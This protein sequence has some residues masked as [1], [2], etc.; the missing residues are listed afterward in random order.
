MRL[1]VVIL[2]GLATAAAT[3]V[4]AIPAKSASS[5]GAEEPAL[6]STPGAPAPA[7]D[8]AVGAALAARAMEEPDLAGRV[9]G[10][11]AALAELPRPT[12]FRALVQAY[13]G[14]ALALSDRLPEARA[15]LEEAHRLL[16]DHAEVS[17]ALG[18][19]LIAQQE[20]VQG[21]RLLLSGIEARPDVM[22]D[23]DPEGLG[24]LFRR[25]AY[26]REFELRDRL[27]LALVRS[28]YVARYPTQ[29]SYFVR[30]AIV[31]RLEAGDI[32]GATALL[33][34]VTEPD[35]AI[36]MIVARQYEKLWP[37]IDRWA[38]GTLREQRLNK[39]RAADAAYEAEPSPSLDATLV[40]ATALYNIGNVAGASELLAKALAEPTKWDAD[41]TDATAIAGRLSFWQ[42][43]TGQTEVSV[44]TGARY[45]AVTPPQR[46]PIVHNLM[47]NQAMRLALLGRNAEALALLD[48]IE[49]SAA[50]DPNFE[51]A[52]AQLWFDAIRACAA[53]GGARDSEA[54]A[55]LGR[56]RRGEAINPDA[57]REALKC[58]GDMEALADVLAAKLGTSDAAR[59]A[60]R[61]RKF[62]VAPSLP[63]GDRIEAEAARNPKVA[64]LLDAASRPVPPSYIDA[65]NGWRR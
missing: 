20:P 13:R 30:P 47:T 28:G 7:G 52:G 8:E 25:L 49:A 59:T 11:D 61:L 58:R 32:A 43:E 39:I 27:M 34:A 46:F 26:S 29:G 38:G 41:R 23:I 9:R 55:A 4:V 3:P 53:R 63:P 51:G 31:S 14:E 1:L 22:V 15:A 62:L 64:R 35:T 40:Y 21:A 24:T 36:E 44:A 12:R 57:Y 54:A 19:V 18:Q 50:S 10:L 45:M 37:A 5:S 56:V 2:L 60:A 65:A 33:A 17:I 42:F 48:A 6:Q 16:P